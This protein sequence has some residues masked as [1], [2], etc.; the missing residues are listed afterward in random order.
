MDSEKLG[1]FIGILLIF[2]FV[3]F[4]YTST[5]GNEDVNSIFSKSEFNFKGYVYA[6]P[7]ST[8]DKNYRLKAD[9]HK[10]GE[11]YEVNRIYFYNGGYIDFEDCEDGNKDGEMFYCAPIDD[12][13]DWG[14]RFYGDII[15]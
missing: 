3:V 5:F 4:C 14:F 2:F 8:K 13:R 9:M 10:D 1:Q 7:D 6:F 11:Y 12:E 15:K